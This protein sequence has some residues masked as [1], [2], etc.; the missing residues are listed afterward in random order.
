LIDAEKALTQ[1]RNYKLL[2]YY[3]FLIAHASLVAAIGD[4]ISATTI[5]PGR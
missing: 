2:A 4:P 1:A 5:M 3:E